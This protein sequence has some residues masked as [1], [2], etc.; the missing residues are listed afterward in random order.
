MASA[1]YEVPALALGLLPAS[2]R[3]R[4]K[5]YAAYSVEWLPITAAA[6]NVQAQFQVDSQTDFVGLFVTGNATDTATPPVEDATPQMSLNFK[7]ADRQTFD[8]N[9]HWRNFVGSGIAPFPLPFPWWLSRAT[10]LTAFLTSLTNV[11]RNVRLTV[12]GFVLH[13]YAAG[14]SRG[15]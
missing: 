6:A 4:A 5:D 7:A 3:A 11:N 8:K 2:D 12:H 13:T 15:Y 14:T 1:T 10:T 9:V